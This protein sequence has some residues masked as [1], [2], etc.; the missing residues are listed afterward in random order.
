[1]VIGTMFARLRAYLQKRSAPVPARSAVPTQYSA[2]VDANTRVVLAVSDNIP[3][4][5]FL[6]ELYMDTFHMT[7]IVW[8]NYQNGLPFELQLPS[9]V[10]YTWNFPARRFEPTRPD[11]ITPELLAQ[12]HMGMKKLR[13]VIHIM[14]VISIARSRI[15]SGIVLQ[16]T[17]YITKKLQAQAFRAGGYDE[18]SIFQYPYVMQYADFADIP[19]RD[20][21]DDIILKAKLDDDLLSKTETL[22]LTYFDRLKKITDAKDITPL[23]ESFAREAF[24]NSY[25]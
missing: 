6:N 15:E 19:Y 21:A 5:S 22:R 13:A 25:V 23:L 10:H 7:N 8:P 1:M 11:V 2:L 3:A 4:I 12:S 17:V 14:H 24:T 20:A 18:R 9:Y 16:E